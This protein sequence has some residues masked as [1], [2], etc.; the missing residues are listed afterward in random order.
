MTISQHTRSEKQF[1]TYMDLRQILVVH[2]LIYMF[3]KAAS[4]GLH[5]LVLLVESIWMKNKAL[6]IIILLYIEEEQAH[7]AMFTKGGHRW[8]LK[9]GK[10]RRCKTSS[11]LVTLCSSKQDPASCFSSRNLS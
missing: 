11:V 5:I 10:L 7:V 6:S 8:S 4:S 1:L 3:C 9:V 2:G